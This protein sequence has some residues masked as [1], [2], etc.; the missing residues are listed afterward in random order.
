LTFFRVKILALV[1]FATLALT[2]SLL[3]E[4]ALDK[5]YYAGRMDKGLSDLD[6]EVFEIFPKVPAI[7]VCIIDAERIIIELA[8]EITYYSGLLTYRLTNILKY[9]HKLVSSTFYPQKIVDWEPESNQIFICNDMDDCNNHG[10]EGFTTVYGLTVENYLKI[11]IQWKVSTSSKVNFKKVTSNIPN[12][13]PK[14]QLKRLVV[15]GERFPLQSIE[16][17][18]NHDGRKLIVFQFQDS[19]NINWLISTTSKNNELI[20]ISINN[21][22]NAI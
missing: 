20:F 6:N 9:K 14:R 4:P 5:C 1:C 10:D 19:S 18:I 17:F 7:H 15:N 8:S 2:S 21:D 16:K 12:S 22:K 11:L 13:N 3:A